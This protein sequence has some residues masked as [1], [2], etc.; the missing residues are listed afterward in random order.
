MQ[1]RAVERV[2]TDIGHVLVLI[3]Y[4][5][6]MFTALFELRYMHGALEGGLVRT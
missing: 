5:F 4:S 2:R 6:R 1:Q 3:V